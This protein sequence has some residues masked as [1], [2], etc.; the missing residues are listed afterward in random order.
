MVHIIIVAHAEIANSFAYCVEHILEKRVES[1][2]IMP[3]KKTQDTKQM[4][5]QLHELV[6]KLTQDEE[7]LILTDLFGATPSNLAK[8]LVMPGKVEMITGLNMPML[9]RA[10][11]YA[12]Q[13][14]SV[15]AARALEGSKSGVVYLNG[16][17]AS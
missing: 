15:C 14:L 6:A 11:T 7:V 1:L 10:I 3:I 2:H 13:D 16:D 5:D 9:I 8:Q 4:L 17:N 12:D